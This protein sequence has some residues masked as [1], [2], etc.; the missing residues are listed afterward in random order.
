MPYDGRYNHLDDTALVAWFHQANLADQKALFAAVCQRHLQTVI[1]FCARQLNERD[2][3]SDAAHDAFLAAFESLRRGTV[4]DA[5][6]PWLIGIARYRCLEYLRG[7]SPDGRRRGSLDELSRD[8]R[9]HPQNANAVA[10]VENLSRR[11]RAE[12]DRLLD[13]VARTLTVKQQE[14]FALSIR[15]GLVGEALGRWIGKESAQASREA[16]ELSAL[17]EEG[18]GALV[19]AREGRPYCA[20]L[21][22]ILDS[23]AAKDGVVF[24]AAL[25]TRIV[26]HFGTCRTCDDCRTCAEQRRRL[27]APLAPVLIPVLVLARTR[28]RI[29]QSVER[30][31]RSTPLPPAPPGPRSRRHRPARA[32]PLL[33]GPGGR[34]SGRARRWAVPAAIVVV[35]LVIL[36]VS[37]LPRLVTTTPAV[38][39]AGPVTAGT[40]DRSGSLGDW[41]ISRWESVAGCA[42]PSRGPSVW[43]FDGP[44][45]EAEPCT[46]NVVSS[47]QGP[48]TLYTKELADAVLFDG[49]PSRVLRFT[50]AAD[51]FRATGTFTVSCDVF[52]D[53]APQEVTDT[54]TLRVTDTTTVAGTPTATRLDITWTTAIV[55]GPIAIERGCVPATYTYTATATRTA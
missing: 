9:V 55:P 20:E 29:E 40:I 46:L 35:V 12:V 30:V 19:L 5:L 34:S 6:L 10:E 44:C 8:G 1:D 2:S 25:R 43:A 31:G 33:V 15:E 53:L 16:Y 39:S 47:E 38:D 49:Q 24:T 32:A 48:D 14:L 7:P 37:F 28:D 27:V 42:S 4:P 23:A 54:V 45:T 26:H 11:R 3:S 51:G 36:G 22:V 50:P 21:A 52:V 13:T 41:Q 18:F 17:L